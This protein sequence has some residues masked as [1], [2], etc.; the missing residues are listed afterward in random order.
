[1]TRP[2]NYQ[3]MMKLIDEI[4]FEILVTRSQKELAS[5][6]VAYKCVKCDALQ[7]ASK[8]FIDHLTAKYIKI[9]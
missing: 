5:E 1:M 4:E 3:V 2:N 6:Q 8:N 9:S 7:V